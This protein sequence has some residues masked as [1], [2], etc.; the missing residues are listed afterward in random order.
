MLGQMMHQPL[1]IKNILA[2]SQMA[3]P[4]TKIVSRTG[5]NSVQ[6]HS[7]GDIARRS[8]QLAHALDAL[9]VQAG[10]RVAT[11]AWNDHRHL[12]LY[13]AVSGIGAVCHTINP[14]LPQKQ[15]AYV[16]EHAGDKLL[17]VDEGL[18]G[19][20]EKVL[21][22]VK[23][24]PTI[25]VL[26]GTT[27]PLPPLNA[28]ADLLNYEVMIGDQADDFDW[29]DFDENTASGMCYTSG[30]T[31]NPKGVLY[32]HRST[33]LHAMQVALSFANALHE[34]ARVLPIVPLFHVN[35]W[36]LPF[37]CPLV[38]ASLIFAGPFLDGPSLFELMDSQQ[39]TSAWG[40]PTV[41]TAVLQEIK[42]AGRPPK[43]LNNI[44]VGGSAISLGFIDDYEDLGITVNHA[45]GMT[46]MSPIGTQGSI[47]A[48]SRHLP[49][50][51]QR[52]LK[53]RQGRGIFGIDMK[54]VDQNGDEI[55][56]DGKQSGEL[57]VRSN[58]TAAQ[59]YNNPEATAEAFHDAGWFRTGDIA[60]I[61]ATG[62][63]LITDRA[64]DLIKSGGEWI[65]SLEHETVIM[66]HKSIAQ[67]AVIAVPHPKWDERP[68][69]IAVPTSDFGDD[70]DSK[71]R[72]ALFEDVLSLLGVEFPKW[73]MPDALVL[74][75][76]L[77]LTA[78]GKISKLRLRQLYRDYFGDTN[79]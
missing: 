32:S 78:T 12:E 74:V 71:V 38:G 43:G 22:L 67:C 33:T 28:D 9:N 77:P 47:P 50:E 42:R 59:Y 63:L 44:L 48:S 34:G 73:Q 51:K 13:Y 27:S 6:S 29:P 69:I 55:A 60:N 62:N 26:A 66:T 5:D 56:Q 23:N 57:Y 40:V 4:T 25:I 41:L 18:A 45:W 70:K 39:V 76:E 37:T 58:T 46:E 79:E 10:D 7:I 19:L 75:D 8:A 64:K 16:I 17:F 14:R 1:L 2:H 31:G 15:I 72:A 53:K 61:D 11:L 52:H 21:P 24:P 30:T 49:L 54:I 36:G 35:A 3:F 65:S 20:L 68:I